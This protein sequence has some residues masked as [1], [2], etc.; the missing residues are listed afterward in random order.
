MIRIEKFKKYRLR[1]HVKTVCLESTTDR[2]FI[3]SHSSTSSELG[4]YSQTAQNLDVRLPKTTTMNWASRLIGSIKPKKILCPFW[5]GRDWPLIPS[6]GGKWL[7]YFEPDWKPVD[8][9]DRFCFVSGRPLVQTRRL[10]FLIIIS[11]A[12]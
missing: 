4:V 3:N 10:L 9:L 12:Y 8:P 2:S 5:H 1:V 7:L 11:S 6:E